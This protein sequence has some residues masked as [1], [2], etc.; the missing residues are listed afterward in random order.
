[1]ARVVKSQTIR[2]FFTLKQF[3]RYYNT[4]WTLEQENSRMIIKLF[5]NT[6]LNKVFFAY[7][8]S[9]FVLFLVKLLC[10]SSSHS[11]DLIS[12]EIPICSIG[13]LHNSLKEIKKIFGNSPLQPDI[14]KQK[15]IISSSP[16]PFPMLV[17]KNE[18]TIGVRYLITDD[19]KVM[20]LREQYVLD[21]LP[22]NRRVEVV[23]VEFGQEE[24][25]VFMNAMLKS[26][27]VLTDTF[28]SAALKKKAKEMDA[29]ATLSS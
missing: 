16:S 7:V 8:G 15:S 12:P 9:D 23:D 18:K 11:S 28:A 29:E 6:E 27:T 26:T 21:H 1:M 2:M 14:S 3:R 19:L 17:V 25:V 4:S 22:E 13:N 5:M 24:A 10:T 20:L